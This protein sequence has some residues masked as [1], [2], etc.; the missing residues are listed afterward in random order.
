MSYKAKSRYDDYDDYDDTDESYS[1]YDFTSMTTDKLLE[2]YSK[3]RKLDDNAQLAAIY[4]ELEKRLNGDDSQL[5]TDPMMKQTLA[6][7]KR[8][9]TSNLNEKLN[10]IKKDIR[11]WTKGGDA[12][13][14]KNVPRDIL[15]KLTAI[16][17]LLGDHI[18]NNCSF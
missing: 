11:H 7:Y 1:S 6:R 2:L 12:T 13:R 4:A 3:A 5:M 10:T 14:I 18:E 8:L 15:I 9:E 16:R 17:L